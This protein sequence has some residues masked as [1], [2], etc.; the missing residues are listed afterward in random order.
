MD[1]SQAPSGPAAA[2]TVAPP[3]YVNGS[4]GR[5][6]KPVTAMQKGKTVATQ[7]DAATYL[8]LNS[9]GKCA[10]CLKYALPEKL[11]NRKVHWAVCCYHELTEEDQ[12]TPTYKNA[13]S[14]RTGAKVS[15]SA[16]GAGIIQHALAAQTGSRAPCDARA[17]VVSFIAAAGQPFALAENP[18][19]RNMLKEFRPDQSLVSAD[20]VS[21]EMKPLCEEVYYSIE[22]QLVAAMT[23]DPDTFK[24]DTGLEFAER[25][26]KPSV[27][28]RD[29]AAQVLFSITLD[30]WTNESQ[31]PYL[32]I[33]LHFIDKD[34]KMHKFTIAID[35]FMHPHTA[36][37]IVES[38]DWALARLGMQT[39]HM[40][41]FTT[42]NGSNMLSAAEV[43]DI[44]NFR[45][46]CHTLHLALAGSIDGPGAPLFKPVWELLSTFARSSA[47]RQALAKA[48]KDAHLSR[49]YMPIYRVVTRWSSAFFSL[50][51]FFILWP[52]FNNLSAA[53]L[54]LKGDDATQWMSRKGEVGEVYS[55]L[56][57][58]MPVLAECQKW[59]VKLQS[60]SA[61]TIS[62][63]LPAW[64][65]LAVATVY[66]ASKHD[67]K[68]KPFLDALHR[69][70][71]DRSQTVAPRG[72]TRYRYL[73]LARFLDVSTGF[74]KAAQLLTDAVDDDTLSALAVPVAAAQGAAQGKRSKVTKSSVEDTKIKLM[75]EDVDDVMLFSEMLAQ[76]LAAG[77]AQRQQDGGKST[78]VQR[79][80][81][82]SKNM[83]SFEFARFDS[84]L[85][86]EDETPT[87]CLDWWR[88]HAAELPLLSSLARSVFS[89][90][91]AS[92]EAERLFSLAGL[93]MTLL[94]NRLGEAGSA[95]V[96]IAAGSR[97]GLDIRSLYDKGKKRAAEKKAAAVDVVT[98][99]DSSDEPVKR[100]REES[101]VSSS[102]LSSSSSSASSS[103]LALADTD[104]GDEIEELLDSGVLRVDVL[105]MHVAEREERGAGADAA[106]TGEVQKVMNVG[107]QRVS[108][109]TK[110]GQL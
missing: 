57:T 42:D 6:R 63:V 73:V 10:N 78:Y 3:Q 12:K 55:S 102:S 39:K 90:Q 66:D 61:V 25:A 44:L 46:S 105:G 56:R 17:A 65:A 106:A 77:V 96:I 94:R 92:A 22:E 31:K 34:M 23:T 76:L 79:K 9:E 50:E 28:V 110:R 49:S 47:R 2:V 24:R 99:G 93:V 97:A 48:C 83:T 8:S 16:A 91:A 82:M 68:T 20:T 41:G 60:S 26:G 89:I 87:N 14:G 29:R 36:E 53:D 71:V 107:P 80:V 75:R 103:V 45:C 37:R 32:G 15:E 104:V 108:T 69:D 64:E 38:V 51:R 35:A 85:K 1:S 52:A 74:A 21:R 101:A 4:L 40:V 54:G 5:A 86:S 72:S 7:D 98:V 11:S 67:A 109:R 30:G 70:I 13:H 27:H 88:D 18:H 95:Q 100:A 33:S 81:E 84:I 62:W 58:I 59:N 43:I 19:F